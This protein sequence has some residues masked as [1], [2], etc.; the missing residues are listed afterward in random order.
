MRPTVKKNIDI[1][2]GEDTMESTIIILTAL[3]AAISEALS[4]IPQVKSNGVFQLIHNL[5]KSL[6][7]R[8]KGV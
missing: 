1:R 3:L 5:L 6:V 2:R 7:G 8:G 4:L